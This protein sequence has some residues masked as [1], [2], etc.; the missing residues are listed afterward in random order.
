MLP[1]PLIDRSSMTA[2]ILQEDLP[3]QNKLR[4]K[5]ATSSAI[6]YLIF[7]ALAK[8]VKILPTQLLSPHQLLNLHRHLISEITIIYFQPA[9]ILQSPIIRSQIQIIS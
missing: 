5:E 8:I 1:S 9:L 2:V 7:S 6:S 3:Y 4:K